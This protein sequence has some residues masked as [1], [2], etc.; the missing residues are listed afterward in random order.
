MKPHALCGRAI[1]AALLGAMLAGCAA[2]RPG[3]GPT[4]TAWV[5]LR[6][7]PTH[8]GSPLVTPTQ[9]ISPLPTA[10]S[11]GLVAPSPTS[12]VSP[13][14]TPTFVSPLST[15]TAPATTT[16]IPSSTPTVPPSPTATP[17]IV[18]STPTRPPSVPTVTR[19]LPAATRAPTLPPLPTR[20]PAPTRTPTPTIPPIQVTTWL[21][22]PDPPP[23]VDV[24][25]YGRLLV[26]GQPVAG[27]GMVARWH[28]KG[29]RIVDCV[30][31]TW[32]DGAA[33]C[34]AN[35]YGLPAGYTVRIEVFIKYNQVPYRA[36]TE[37]TIR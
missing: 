24:K 3:P 6:A 36:T 30:G 11:S 27:E 9:G 26:N 2:T 35:T 37:L 31:D 32:V 1:L 28:M 33:Y 13:L 4:S 22:D 7:M 14:S 5:N 20:T 17:L 16:S 8:V 29:G 23:G 15:P 19:A 10:T 34:T 21:S 25:V 12:P 18:V